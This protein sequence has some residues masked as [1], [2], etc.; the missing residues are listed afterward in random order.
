MRK[1]FKALRF[2]LLL[3]TIAVV[4]YAAGHL[5]NPKAKEYDLAESIPPPGLSLSGVSTCVEPNERERTLVKIAVDALAFSGDEAGLLAIGAQ[6]FL[7]HGL[8]RRADR[9]SKRVCDTLPEYERAAQF[10][11]DSGHLQRGRLVEYGLELIARLPSP[12]ENLAKVVAASAFNDSV[13]QSEIFPDRDIRPLARATLAGLGK[14]A[15]PYADQAFELISIEDSM[16]T[17]AAQIAVAGEHPMAL[18][19]VERVMADRLA[20]LPRDRVVPRDIRNRLYEMAYALAFGGTQAK[21]HVAPLR[22]LM[23]RKV[24]SWAPPFGMIE[25]PPRRMCRVLAKITDV[26]VTDLEFDYCADVDATYEQ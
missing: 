17:G 6:K 5:R 25:L 1:F 9:E 7:S 8:Y 20:T 11:N 26:P 10:I 19:T 21:Q 24:Q 23:S 18:E 4:A 22:D 15:Q 3:T 12:S 16:G 2:P 14:R 13:Q